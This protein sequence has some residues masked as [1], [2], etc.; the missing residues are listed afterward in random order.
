MWDKHFTLNVAIDQATISTDQKRI[1]SFI[2]INDS[3][4]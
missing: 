3:S 4:Y 1:A 2:S